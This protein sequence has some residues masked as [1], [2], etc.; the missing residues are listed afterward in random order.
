MPINQKAVISIV[1]A[2]FNRKAQLEKTL[3]SIRDSE[4]K[5][6]EIVIVDDASDEPLVCEEARVIRIE[7]EDKW[8]IN[9]C[10]PF[11]IGFKEAKGDIVIIQNP[12]CEH[13]GDILK[14][15]TE[16]ISDGRYISFACYAE[17]KNIWFN[18]SKYRPVGYHFCS[19][20]TIDELQLIGGFD[21]RYALGVSYDDDDFI[22]KVRRNMEVWLIDNP[23]VLHQY[24][25]PYAYRHKDM[26][27]LHEKN[28]KIFNGE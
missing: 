11:N 8:W 14:Y 19:A 24:H 9:P 6:Y 18:H 10:I 7:K 1:M 23:Y 22:R 28:K 2:Y 27:R 25:L 5:D 17:K 26:M 20:I 12:E 4:V 13:K 16:N 15:V 3:V 21:E